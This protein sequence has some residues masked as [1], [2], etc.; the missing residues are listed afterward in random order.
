MD[1]RF[2]VHAEEEVARRGIPREVIDAV[3]RE[4]DEKVAG[5][6]GRRVYQSLHQ[7]AGG[8]AFLVRVVVDER[9]RPPLVIT[10]YRTS[11]IAKYRRQ[12]P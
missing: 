6:G 2:A 8:K 7:F 9:L 12:T 10:A 5:F 3:L 4:P 1:F 11:K